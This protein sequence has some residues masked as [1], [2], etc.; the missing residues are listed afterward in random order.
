MYMIRFE[1]KMECVANMRQMITRETVRTEK[2]NIE[3]GKCRKWLQYQ[4]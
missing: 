4:I 3:N 1:Q 2:V